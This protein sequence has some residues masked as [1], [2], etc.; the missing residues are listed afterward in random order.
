MIVAT[1]GHIDHG[2]TTLVRTLTGIDTDRLPEEKARGI[3]IDLGFAHWKAPNGVTIG[4]VDVPGHERFIRNMLCGVCAIDH[5]LLVVAAD[6]GVMPQTREHLSIVDLLGVRHGTV[7][8][9]KT[10]RVGPERVAQ[11]AD[12][13]A[14]LLEDTALAGSPLIR[15]CATRGD[16]IEGLRQRLLAAAE[17]ARPGGDADACLPRYII[18]RVF[19]ITGSGTVVT[20]TVLAGAISA[21]Q[22]MMVSPAGKEVRVRKL[23]RHGEAVA[24]ARAG[25]R[26][27]INLT[28][29]D[30]TGLGRGDWLV[31]PQGHAPTDRMAVRLKLLTG[32][33]S[34]LKH[35]TPV[36]VHIGAADVLARIATRRGRSIAPGASALV[37]LRLDK[38]VSACH[39]DR[40]IIRDQ[41]AM[42]TLGGGRVV[43]PYAAIRRVAA[44]RSTVHTALDRDEPAEALAALLESSTR[45]VDLHWFAQVFNLRSDRVQRLLPAGTVVLG[46]EPPTAVRPQWLDQVCASVV[47]W[48]GGFHRQQAGAAG[49]DASQLQRGVAPALDPGLF[50]A[51]L[52]RFA[53]QGR[54]A[55]QGQLVHLPAHDAA[56]NPADAVRWQ[57][58]VPLLQAAAA[59]I[60]SVRELAARSGV[61]LQIL[62]DVLHRK[63]RSGQLVKVTPER[64]ALPQTLTVLAEQARQTAQSCPGGLFTAAHYRDRIGTGRGLAIEVLECLDRLGIT[65]REGAG[66]RCTGARLKISPEASEPGS[67]P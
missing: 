7:A 45:G 56:E 65:R 41:S 23:Q 63:S 13:V 22:K 57:K 6:D 35:W 67:E 62:R 54:I 60:P 39:G 15:V 43:D 14:L 17:I 53:A 52:K 20:G 44:E 49:V 64:F 1:A 38:P 9:T 66:R 48:V 36:H 29:V 24:S 2:K 61:P 16:G 42:A 28:H 51:M 18:D 19:T 46:T 47:D 55:F 27:A 32:A 50:A 58:V 5:V 21:N 26:C 10:D 30:P 11:V 8:I 33:G 3:S 34:P 4:F 59:E 12:E 31:A 37:Q 40:L 25:E